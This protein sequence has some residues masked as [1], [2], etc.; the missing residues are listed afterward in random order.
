LVADSTSGRGRVS[1]R[2]P[3]PGTKREDTPGSELERRVARIEFGE[4]AVTRL[5]VPV[6]APSG[7]SGREV[8]TDIDVLSLDVDL[9]L[10]VSRSSAECK[11]S[12]GQA[13]EPQT[14]VWLAG[15]RQLLNLDRVTFVR[16]AISARGRELARRLG[17]SSL[18]ETTLALRERAHQWLPE[19][20]AHVDG[21]KCIAAEARTDSQLRGLPELSPQLVHFL[22][23]DALLAEPAAL[24]AGVEA[25]GDAVT[26]Q[27]ALPDPAS[28]ILAGHA[29][30]AIV[31]AGVQDA[32]T[33]DGRTPQ[34]LRAGL[35]RDLISSEPAL[36]ALLDRA[37]DLMRH[38]VARIHR[39]YVAGGAEP[40]GSTVP[41][42]KESILRPLPFLDDYVDFVQR[43]RANP[44]IA[45]DL[46]Q[47][48]ELACFDVILDDDGWKSPSFGHLFTAEHKGLLLVAL[49]CLESVAGGQVAI[50]LRGLHQ[51]K[52]FAGQQGIPDRSAPPSGLPAARP[53]TITSQLEQ[54]T[55][56]DLDEA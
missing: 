50:P 20:F 2:T 35:A 27:G 16:P 6:A 47:T 53:T 26:A 10:R 33:L 29:L 13:G 1:R 32:A 17:I 51:L 8:L 14:L 37:D 36:Y 15:F 23:F 42:L 40:V 5:R 11:S 31:L 21:A 12:R 4:G 45:R 30:F 48:T 18:D 46:L 3:A 7:E 24:L 25:L 52:V 22:R 55:I 28:T 38:I 43:L 56:I 19:R 54:P 49:R 9:R 34:E 41:S 44:T 39:S